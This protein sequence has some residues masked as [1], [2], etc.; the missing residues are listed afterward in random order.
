VP[1]CRPSTSF[2]VAIDLKERITLY[3]RTGGG[4]LTAGTA[5]PLAS[6]LD[7]IWQTFIVA[8]MLVAGFSLLRVARRTRIDRS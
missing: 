6:G 3:A 7:P 2:L 8:A 4:L 5:V 1:G